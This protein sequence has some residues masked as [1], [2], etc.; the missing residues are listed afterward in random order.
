MKLV[1]ISAMSCIGLLCFASTTQSANLHTALKLPGFNLG[2]NKVLEELINT[3]KEEL[4]SI[5]RD[6]SPRSFEELKLIIDILNDSIKSSTEEILKTSLNAF[7]FLADAAK[8]TIDYLRQIVEFE[9]RIGIVRDDREDNVVIEGLQQLLQNFV[10][11]IAKLRGNWNSLEKEIA[12]VVVDLLDE[13]QKVDS[14]KLAEEIIATLPLEIPPHLRE[15]IGELRDVIVESI[16]NT[17]DFF[18]VLAIKIRR[19]YDL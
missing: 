13:V 18:R 6:V 5:P 9:E 14:E 8:K 10:E 4:K 16:E 19:E 17:K 1:L 7:D 2:Q 11:W 3:Y 12:R 15:G